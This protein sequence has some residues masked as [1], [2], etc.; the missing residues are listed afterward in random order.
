MD[1][2]SMLCWSGGYI[3]CCSDKRTLELHL[4][5]WNQRQN[6]GIAVSILLPIS[7]VLG[8]TKHNKIRVRMYFFPLSFTV[9]LEFLELTKVLF[10][11]CFLLPNTFPPPPFYFPWL[12]EIYSEIH[13]IT[14][15]ELNLEENFPFNF[16][17]RT[18][19]ISPCCKSF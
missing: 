15:N 17:N 16:P 2:I 18:D 19:D 12:T 1:L 13:S 11:S 3:S 5:W 6:I 7:P 8:K 4:S 10:L 9:I 14:A